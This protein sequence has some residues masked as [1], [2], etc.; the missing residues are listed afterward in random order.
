MYRAKQAGRNS[1]QFYT[2]AHERARARSAAARAPAAP[3]ARARRV[4]AALPAEG[5]ARDR[6]ASS[7]SRRC[8]AGSTR[9][10]G[11]C[12]PARVHPGAGGDRAD[13]RRSGDWVLEQRLRADRGLAG[14]PGSTAVRSRSTSRRAS[15]AAAISTRA[16]AALL[17]RAGV[18]PALLELEITESAADAATP[19]ARIA[20]CCAAARAGRA[21]RD[22]RLRH[23]LLEPRLPEALPGR[24]AEDRPRRSS[25]DV[26]RATRAT[27]RSSRAIIDAGAQP[28]A[29]GRRRGRGD[30]GA[31]ASFLRELRLR[32][33]RRATC[34]PGRCPPPSW[35]SASPRPSKNRI[36]G[37]SPICILAAAISAAASGRAGEGA[38]RRLIPVASSPRR[39]PSGEQCRAASRRAWI[40]VLLDDPMRPLP[41]SAFEVRYG[42]ADVVER[43]RH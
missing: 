21:H 34:S 23:R 29:Q 43:K 24:R 22:R 28:A 9:S 7:A 26:D 16:I 17:A 18:D 27:R 8:C 33:R 32:R 5:R 20:R 19:S 39:P 40:F 37:Q 15:S 38:L 10:A 31:A 42:V 1:F 35:R 11:W 36:P 3:R 25:R 4:R 2:P 6:R 30:R 41:I 13:R 14:A 12:S